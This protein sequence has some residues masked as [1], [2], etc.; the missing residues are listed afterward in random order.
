VHESRLLAGVLAGRCEP[1]GWA[2]GSDEKVDLYDLMGCIEDVRSVVGWH[3]GHRWVSTALPFLDAK[4]SAELT[5]PGGLVGWAGRID[6]PVLRAFDLD[7]AVYAF[8]LNITALMPKKRGT[9]RYLPFSRFP[10]VSRDLALVA[11]LSV[12]AGALIATANRAARKSA[13]A[14]FQTVDVFDVY[15]G[16]GVPEGYRSVALRFQFRSLDSTLEDALVDKAMEKIERALT[17]DG[18]VSVRR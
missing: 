4:E 10:G 15:Q 18:T 12:Q 9:V 6:V 17:E 11:P 2:A 8:E 5:G 14:A 13:K 7:T 3:D 16:K 1:V